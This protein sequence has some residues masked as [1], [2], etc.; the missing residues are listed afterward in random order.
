M[1]IKQAMAKTWENH[2]SHHVLLEPR[3]CFHF[4]M[5]EITSHELQNL[6]RSVLRF[7]HVV[8]HVHPDFNSKAFGRKPR[9]APILYA[10]IRNYHM[11]DRYD[12]HPIPVIS[13]G[14][15]KGLAV[16]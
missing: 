7:G 4:I 15:S 14:I 12:T 16:A 9:L 13:V 8:R 11:T 3:L 1:H 10:E 5:H 2:T 6:N